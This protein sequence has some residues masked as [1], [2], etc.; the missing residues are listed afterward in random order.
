MASRRIANF[1]LDK[2]LDKLEATRQEKAAKDVLPPPFQ[3]IKTDPALLEL[4][5]KAAEQ[6]APSKDDTLM[7]AFQKLVTKKGA[8]KNPLPPAPPPKKIK[9][10]K[11]IV[12][13]KKGAGE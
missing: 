6:T 4:L 8:P 9:L 5:K 3:D 12:I 2:M 10:M 13:K 7:D 1:D 11:K